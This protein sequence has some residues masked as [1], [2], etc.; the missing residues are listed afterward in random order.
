MMHD[1]LESF[2][3]PQNTAWIEEVLLTRER[4]E[5]ISSIQA[6]SQHVSLTLPD[7]RN[8]GN[9]EVSSDSRQKYDELRKLF[10]KW[11]YVGII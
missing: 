3:G 7:G 8:G 11:I 2:K 4:I 10:N 9:G 1:V 6:E 5:S